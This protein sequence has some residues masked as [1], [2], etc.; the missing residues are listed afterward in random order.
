MARDRKLILICEDGTQ[1]TI[2]HCWHICPACDGEGRS[3]AYLGVITR[4]DADDEW[5]E[6]YMSGRFDR[7]CG[8]CDGSGKVQRPNF[9]QMTQAQQA[10]W[11][12]QEEDRAACAAEHRQERL[13]EGGWRDLGWRSES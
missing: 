13:L 6:D 12:Q 3:S 9:A 5:M 10:A 4:E 1:K 11:E 7:A 2:P 8:E